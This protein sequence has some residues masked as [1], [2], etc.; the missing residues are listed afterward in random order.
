[1]HEVSGLSRNAPLFG[2]RVTSHVVSIGT[3]RRFEASNLKTAETAMQAR[4]RAIVQLVALVCVTIAVAG[5]LRSLQAPK[6]FRGTV[7]Y[8]VIRAGFEGSQAVL[9][10]STGSFDLFCRQKFGWKS[11]L[12]GFAGKKV[13]VIG[14]SRMIS[15]KYRPDY[16]AIGVIEIALEEEP[17]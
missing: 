6:E 2:V 17:K 8:P 7:R 14:R 15:G 16:N 9:V 1:M 11:K 4:T 10:T 5:A 3:T 12:E 13:V